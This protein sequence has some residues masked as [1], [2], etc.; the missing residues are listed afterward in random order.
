M[1]CY[2]KYGACFPRGKKAI[3]PLLYYLSNAET[4]MQIVSEVKVC[5]YIRAC[6]AFLDMRQGAP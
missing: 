4:T 6:I 1:C 5:H 3:T 2:N